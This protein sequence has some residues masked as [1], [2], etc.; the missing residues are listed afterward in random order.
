MNRARVNA[1]VDAKCLSDRAKAERVDE[2][3]D[4]LTAAQVQRD[5]CHGRLAQLAAN[6]PVQPEP[7]RP[8]LWVRIA[9]DVT[10][11]ATAA[12]TG[13]AAGVGAPGEL[14]V[15]LAVG[16]VAVLVGRIVL[17]LLR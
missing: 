17:E 1:L 5:Q 11:G 9:L 14:V 8:P 6:P 2:L 10:V 15:G 4:D 3:T 7:W 13:A 12:G 16:S